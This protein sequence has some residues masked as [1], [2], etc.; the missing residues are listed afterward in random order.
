MASRYHP[1]PRFKKES[2]QGRTPCRDLF[3][4]LWT[5]DLFMER[6]EQN[7]DWS[8]FCPNECPGLQDA[9]G[10]EFKQLYES[11]EAQGLARETVPARTV[12]DKVVEA[13]IETGTPYMLY[14]DSANMKSNQKNLGTIRSSNLCTEI[15]E[16]TS[17]DEV[18]VCNLASI[19]LPRFV[20][21]ESKQFDFQKLYDVTYHVTGNLNRV[22]DVNYYP[23]EEARNSNMRHR[24][25]GLG[26]QGLADTFA[27]LGMAFESDE[28]K[29][30]TKKSLKQFTCIMYSIKGRCDC[31][32]PYSSFKGSPASQGILQFDLWNMNEHSGRW[33]WESLKGEI[34][35]HG[36]RNSL[37]LVQCQLQVP[38]ILGNNECFEAFTSNLYVRRTLSGEFVVTNK[39]LIKDLIDLGLWSLEMKD[40]ILRHKGQFKP[41]LEYQIT[42]RNYTRPL[43]KS[44]KR[45]SLTWRL[46][47]AHTLTKVNL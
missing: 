42:L 3:Y 17:K 39:H 20:N 44:S 30:L 23:V 9:Y 21:Q 8:F 43:G 11:Y 13:Q 34:V 10:E 15:M 27:M 33:D 29:A 6:V 46:I 37:L 36:M 28:A 47:E 32:G 40:E 26:V 14:K 31:R 19:A 24:P 38:Q 4:A 22:I 45:M 41:L 12:W 25:I 16:Y 5:P 18:A 2:R 35:E 7:A 1:I